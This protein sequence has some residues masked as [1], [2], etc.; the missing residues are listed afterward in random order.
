MNEKPPLYLYV[1][2]PILLSICNAS[3]LMY[4]LG[5]S[6]SSQLYQEGSFQE[7][8]DDAFSHDL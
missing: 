7:Y 4:Y 2:T 3:D 8:L 5:A 1:Q 6:D